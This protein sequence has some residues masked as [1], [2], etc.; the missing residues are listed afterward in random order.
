MKASASAM[1]NKNDFFHLLCKKWAFN[2]EISKAY[3]KTS[4]DS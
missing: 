4:L 1:I 3:L 2:Y